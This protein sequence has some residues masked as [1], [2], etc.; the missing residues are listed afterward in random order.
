MKIAF[1]TQ[2]GKT[3]SKHFG[4]APYYLVVTVEAGREVS[5]EMRD[6]LSHTHFA[7]EPHDQHEGQQA[8]HG[9]SPQE[10]NRHFQM[11][12]AIADCE[13]LVCGG[14]GSGAYQNLNERGIKTVLTDIGP[15]D[16][17][18][19]AHLEGRLVDL[20]ADMLH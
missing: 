10:Q 19:K 16:D 12:N 8:R 20:A 14:M 18:L 4:R 13:A 1:I 9:F 7:T 11:A 17:A 2:D 15:I 3:I 6:K 5:R